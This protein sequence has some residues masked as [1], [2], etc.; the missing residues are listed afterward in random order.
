VFTNIPKKYLGLGA[1]ALVVL[2]L[3]IGYASVNGKQKDMV[4]KEAALSAQYLDTQNVLNNYVAKIRESL[5]VAD[6]NTAALDQVLAD[7]VRGR[8]DGDTSAQPGGGQLFSAITEA[9][10]DLS[11]VSINYA[12]VQSAVFAGRDAFQNEQSKMLDMVRDYNTWRNSGF[13]HSAIVGLIGAPS[14]NLAANNGTDTVHGQAALDRM[15]D[16]IRTTEGKTA[17]DTGV[18]DPLNLGPTT[19]ASTPTN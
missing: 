12:N 10:P 3:L 19:P 17:Y 14:D 15:N 13:L 8:Y 5:G 1:V 6:R 7:A 11:G 4:A 2:L 9:Y 18:M 16:I